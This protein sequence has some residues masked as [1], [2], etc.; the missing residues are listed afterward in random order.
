MYVLH[1]SPRSELWHLSLIESM[2]EPEILQSVLNFI[3]Y[4]VMVHWELNTTSRCG[5][6][7][8]TTS[9]PDGVFAPVLVPLIWHSLRNHSCI[10]RTLGFISRKL[11]WFLEINCIVPGQ[12]SIAM[13]SYHPWGHF[14]LWNELSCCRFRACYCEL[15]IKI[16]DKL[17]NML[18]GKMDIL[19]QF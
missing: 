7:N 2:L 19:L 16:Y 14:E 18:S 8:H 12:S 5:L 10:F 4:Y 15:Q 13:F 3:S 6:L 1:T 11:G 9:D 17:N